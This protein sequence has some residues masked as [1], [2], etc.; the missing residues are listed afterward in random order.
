MKSKTNT[1]VETIIIA[2]LIVLGI[3]AVCITHSQHFHSVTDES[4]PTEA[5]T[6]ETVPLIT[7]VE[8]AVEETQS[9]VNNSVEDV[10]NSV[11]VTEPSYEQEDLDILALIIYQEAGGDRS[12]DDTRRKVG[13]VFLNRVAHPKFPNT[14]EA[15]ATARRQYGTLYWTGLKWPDRAS[16]SSE[17][18]AVDRAYEIA[19]E[20]LTTGSILPANVIWQAEFKQGDG[21]YCLQDG[22]YFC[23]S[24]GI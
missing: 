12:S 2:L 22:I 8:E 24:G 23:Y 18:H 6:T 19:K 21:V 5:P 3:V 10:N 13:S 20:L 11:E 17:A 7:V 14:F 4:L 15:V 16:S 9:A 1:I